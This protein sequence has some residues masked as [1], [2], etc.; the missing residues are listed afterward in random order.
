[1]APEPSDRAN[2]PGSHRPPRRAQRPRH[3]D[4]RWRRPPAPRE[5]P[6]GE[7]AIRANRAAGCSGN[8]CARPGPATAAPGTG[9]GST[10][11]ARRRSAR[12]TP[13]RVACPRRTQ[14]QAAAGQD[15]RKI[16]SGPAEA[17]TLARLF[18][19]DIRMKSPPARRRREHDICFTSTLPGRAKLVP[20]GIDSISQLYAVC[21]HR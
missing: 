19:Y 14:A 16:A 9:H 6:R 5:S 2:H 3:R 17:G 18:C 15:V 4:G 10:G 1:M 7:A 12:T 20:D 13:G 11:G 8:Q 21:R